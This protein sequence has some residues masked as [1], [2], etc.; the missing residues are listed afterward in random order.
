ME[1]SNDNYSESSDGDGGGGEGGGEI[2]ASESSDSESSDSESS[3]SERSEEFPDDGSTHYLQHKWQSLHRKFNKTVKKTRDLTWSIEILEKLDKEIN[4][5]LGDIL[6]TLKKKH[7]KHIK[8]TNL[9]R[10]RGQKKLRQK[11]SAVLEIQITIGEELLAL[12]AR[13]NARLNGS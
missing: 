12:K 4:D 11:L 1:D 6:G 3:D 9:A 5:I 7:H 10:I 2:S 13:L 8:A